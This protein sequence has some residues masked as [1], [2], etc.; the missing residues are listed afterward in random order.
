[1]AER[2]YYEQR[3]FTLSY[4]LPYFEQHIP[5]FSQLKILDVGCAEAGFIDVLNER[6]ITAVGIELSASRVAIARKKNPHLE[7]YTGDITDASVIEK[8][9]K[10]FDLIVLRDVIE[11]IENRNAAFK[12]LNRLLKKGGM[13]YITFPPKY[14]PF[15]GHQQNGKSI[16]RLI[17]YLHLLPSWLIRILGKFT[18]E[19]PEFIENVINNFET[20]LTISKFE[21]FCKKYNLQFTTHELYMIRPI[22]LTR[23]GLRPRKSTDIPIL[24]ET[25]SLSCECLLQSS[26]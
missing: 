16:L 13:L 17:P 11:H 25:I 23:F 4:L 5:H 15:A 20:G 2:H 18:G 19:N 1:M 26:L 14:S 24:R 22:F 21:R 6:G 9:K 8:V 7:I 12:N 3:N 10:K